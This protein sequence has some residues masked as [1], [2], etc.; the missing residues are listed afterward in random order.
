MPVIGALTALGLVAPALSALGIGGG[1]G[2]KE[3]GIKGAISPDSTAMI[4][5][6]NEVRDAINKLYGKDSSVYLDGKEV[7]KTL[8][9]GSHKVA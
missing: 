5:A 4:T 7:G 6:I 3:E 1:G 9:Q 8:V 2:T